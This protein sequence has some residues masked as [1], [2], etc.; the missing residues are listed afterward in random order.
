MTSITVYDGTNTIGGNK[1]YVEENNRGLFLDFGMN[2]KK[3]NYY[4]Q[5]YLTERS[6]RG[7]YDL[8]HLNLIPKLNIYRK[9]LIPSDLDLSSSPKLD[10]DAI[11]V[12]HPHM[13]HFGNI[14][15]LKTDIPIIASPITFALI[16]GM[17]DSSNLSLNLQA[18]Y[19]S[20]KLQDKSGM[21]L[22]SEKGKNINYKTR[23]LVCIDS[24]SDGL[25]SFITTNIKSAV[26]KSSGMLKPLE[27]EQLTDLSTNP[28]HF[29]INAFEVDHSIYGATAYILEG[30]T[31][32]AYSGDFR[33]HG[34]N[35]YKSEHF[36]NSAKDASI[37]IIEGTRASR[38]D[39]NESEEIVYNSCLDVISQTKDLV[40]ADFSARNFERLETF[41]DVGKKVNRKVVIPAKQAYLLRALEQIDNVD[42]TSDIL[43]FEEKKGSKN[44]WE[45]NFLQDEVNYIDSETIVKN[46]GA[47]ILCFSFY[48]VKHLLDVNPKH[49]TYI[50]SSSE[51]FDE[52]SEFD[53]V[54]LNNWL[55]YF[56]FTVY[57]FKMIDKNG[58]DKP[59]FMKGFHASGHA[60][61]S[62]LIH[63]IETIDP[64]HIIPVHTENPDWFKEQFDN[65]YLLEE[66]KKINF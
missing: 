36:I 57:G 23:K 1:I 47:Y 27:C 17:A 66:G 65:V 51:A 22:K 7:I 2:F 14:G 11:L 24:I 58:I 8:I 46:Q 45:T 21:I 38:Q 4:F 39:I 13:D 9:D 56:N 40:V 32:I 49:G 29:E 64:D 6:V 12:S 50:Y 26:D 34:K 5:E 61:K 16:K 48:E 15:L 43:V 37:L 19:Y 41:K 59:E 25:E 44:K 63:A 10:I 60:S 33:L 52:E 53:F 42:R 35:G 18:V 54:R 28:T 20:E 31:T 30:N 55:K 62:D 3:Y